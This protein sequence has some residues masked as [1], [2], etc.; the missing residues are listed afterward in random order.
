L[1]I[2]PVLG[3]CAPP[4][5]NGEDGN[6][7][8]DLSGGVRAAVNRP[9]DQLAYTMDF[10]GPGGES[11]QIK[12]APGVENVTLTLALGDWTVWVE[13]DYHG[14]LVGTGKADFPVRS[15]RNNRA[16]ITM[17]LIPGGGFL[18]GINEEDFGGFA[19]IHNLEVSNNNN[20]ADSASWAHAMKAI[21][22]GGPDKNYIINLNTDVTSPGSTDTGYTFGSD[23]G[24]TVSLR[25][26]KT[27]R[28]A[29]PGH[30]LNI[31]DGQTLIL[32]G[33]T[34]EGKNSNTFPLVYVSGSLIMHSGEITG[35][36]SSD[37][38]G[39][40]YLS[41]GVFTMSGEAKI[42]GNTASPFG[43]GVYVSGGGAFTMYGQA[44]IYGN[45]TSG[46]NGNG[47]G[48]YVNSGAFTMSGGAKIYDNTASGT[49]GSGGGVYVNGGV[50]TMSGGIISGNEVD[51]DG[52]GV[53]VGISGTF[54]KEPIFPAL[55]SGIIYGEN[56]GTLSN[57]APGSGPAVYGAGSPPVRND[58]VGE[59]VTFDGTNWAG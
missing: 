21:R 18:D 28:L 13:A 31:K 26:D 7:R 3:A 30:L 19:V 43:G 50:F 24:I 52:G 37:C 39:G 6:V 45:T 9:M 41:G 38:G 35:N 55:T 14:V 20:E 15:G 33:N 44:E 4:V 25:G 29:T 22:D 10:S 54:K 56:E 40:V 11:R 8:I 36:S 57:T 32:R 58:T 23:A 53:C 27:L 16:E 46:T 49:N 34:L 5:Q 1:I 42:S 12:T 59:G 48:V 47:G 51:D 2:L 17:Y